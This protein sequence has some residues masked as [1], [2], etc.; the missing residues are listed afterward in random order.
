MYWRYRKYL[1]AGALAG[2][3]LGIADAV[4][5]RRAKRAEREVWG[6]ARLSGSMGSPGSGDEGADSADGSA[7]DSS[8]PLPDMP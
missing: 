1:L 7:T 2:A 5:D 4:R 8:V 3:A 6:E